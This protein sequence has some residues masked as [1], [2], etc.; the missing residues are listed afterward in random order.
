MLMHSID[1][2][3]SVKSVVETVGRNSV[4]VVT[5]GTGRKPIQDC[6][7]AWVLGR[8]HPGE[9]TSSFMIEGVINYLVS[10]YSNPPAE[11]A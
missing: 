6:A 10:V 3:I 11:F 7:V 5:I 2:V 1:S 4:N 8:Q 9:T